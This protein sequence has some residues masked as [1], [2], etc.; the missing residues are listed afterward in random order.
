MKIYLASFYEKHNHGNG[1]KFSVCSSFPEDTPTQGM[2]PYLTPSP[3]ILSEYDKNKINIEIS[4]RAGEIFETSF[5][6]EL[7]ALY[8]DLTEES[9]VN[10]KSIMEILPFEDGDT[11]LS[12]EREH[13]TNY[14]KNIANILQKIGYEVILA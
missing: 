6:K 5:K 1:R 14:R 12:W 8:L 10:N 13:Y 4:A 9:K 7:D 3:S 11:L 2:I